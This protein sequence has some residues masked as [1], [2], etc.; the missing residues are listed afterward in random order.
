MFFFISIQTNLV[1]QYGDY[2]FK[3]HLRNIWAHYIILKIAAFV[4]KHA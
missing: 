2:K 3:H 4:C 1:T